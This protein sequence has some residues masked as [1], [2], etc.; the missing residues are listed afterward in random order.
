MKAW[1]IRV[2]IGVALLVVGA[3]YAVRAQEKKPDILVQIEI[4]KNGSS[5][6]KPSFRLHDGATG[7]LQLNDG[8][9]VTI[10][11]SAISR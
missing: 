11:A 6:A 3:T 9:K 8:S 7:W 5:V 4:S 1:Y 2:A 10:T